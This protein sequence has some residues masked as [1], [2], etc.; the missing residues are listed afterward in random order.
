M[1]YSKTG[2][3]GIGMCCEKKKMIGWR[4][5]WSMKWRV[6]DQEV[7]QRELGEKRVQNDCQA[8]KLNREDA[9]VC[10]RWKKLIKNG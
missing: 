7:D 6:P 3:G 1:Y 4:N 5:V 9:V 2:C 8:H 10:S